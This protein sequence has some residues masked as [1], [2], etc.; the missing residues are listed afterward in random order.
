MKKILITIITL[1]FISCAEWKDEKDF[2]NYLRDQ[3]PYSELIEMRGFG[4]CYEVRDTINSEHWIYKSLSR[5][6]HSVVRHFIK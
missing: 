6:E 1:S 3:H 5:K 2:R 4:W